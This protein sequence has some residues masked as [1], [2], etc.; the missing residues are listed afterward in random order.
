MPSEVVDIAGAGPDT[1]KRR[2]IAAE[3]LEKQVR[4]TWNDGRTAVFHFLWLRDN[5][6]CPQCRHPETLERSFDLLSVSE[7]LHTRSVAVAK[8]GALKIIWSVDGHE[9]VYEPQWLSEYCGADQVSASQAPHRRPW[10]AGMAEQLPTATYDAVMARDRDLLEWLQVLR[11]QGV[12]V[13]RGVP[14]KFQ[15]V[16][17]VAERI[18]FARASNFGV[19]FDVEAKLEPNSTAYTALAL[20]NHT[21]IP[22]YELPPGIQ[23]LHCLTSDAK[24][25]NSVVVDGFAVAEALREEDSEAFELMARVPIGFRF[26]DANSDYRTSSSAI[27]LDAQGS[28]CEFRFNPFLTA[29]FTVPTD[30]MDALYKA[31]RKLMALTRDARFEVRLRLG[32]GDLIGV[33]NRRVLHG[34]DAFEADSGHRHLQG[35]Y[36]DRDE[37]INRIRVLEHALGSSESLR[38]SV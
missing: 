27:V 8:N 14:C 21:D 36:V 38:N 6:H 15:Q 20:A 19:V 35:C 7:D 29:P 25:G 32:P 11:D 18:A 26:E 31:F 16:L 17:R 33:D 1:E 12:V 13:M 9:S 37:I 34:R 30:E 23:F 2:A 5:C 24:G 3:P 22:F 4:V 28:V 10:G